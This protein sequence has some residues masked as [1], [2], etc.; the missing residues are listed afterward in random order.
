[1]VPWHQNHAPKSV[2]PRLKNFHRKIKAIRTPSKNSKIARLTAGY[3]L[4]HCLACARALQNCVRS[5]LPRKQQNQTAESDS[6][7]AP[8]LPRAVLRRFRAA[9]CASI[10]RQHQN[11]M[12]REVG[13][14]RRAPLRRPGRQFRYRNHQARLARDQHRAALKFTVPS[15]RFRSSASSTARADQT[16]VCARP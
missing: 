12:H 7:T 10:L 5:A 11:S 1:M 3:F 4:R 6:A 2:L 13:R 16:R 9:R 15:R 14:G 8:A